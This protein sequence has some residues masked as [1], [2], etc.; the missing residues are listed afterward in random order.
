M[1]AGVAATETLVLALRVAHGLLCCPGMATAAHL[2]LL[3]RALSVFA[4]NASAPALA[5]QLHESAWHA[6]LRAPEL[7]ELVA[8]VHGALDFFAGLLRGPAGVLDHDLQVRCI[9]Q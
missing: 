6:T 2:P 4:G 8:R 5:L 9:S 3:G 1:D 7:S